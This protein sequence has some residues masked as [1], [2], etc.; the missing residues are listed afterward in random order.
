MAT[1]KLDIKRELKAVDTRD[2]NFYDNLTDEEKKAFSPYILMRYT[3]NVQGDQ[4]LQEWFLET[5]NEYVNKNH[6]EL[7]K[8][9]K[10]LL[11]KLFAGTG[12]GTSMYH[13][14]LAAGKK[15]K[16]NKIEKLLAEIYPA[17]KLEDIKILA[18]MMDKKDIEEL[19]DKMGFDKKQRKEYE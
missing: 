5:T 18:S 6:W 8:N 4:S 9:H 12:I 16:A 10:P 14:Y 13:P 19:F 15:G 3:A 7:S 11:W 17:R 2:Y 1:A